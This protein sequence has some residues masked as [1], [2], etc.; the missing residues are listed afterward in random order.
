VS[1]SATHDDAATIGA[2]SLLAMCLV[3]FDHEALG[4]GG[5]C[6]AL[7]GRILELTSSIFRCDLR[8][9]WIS[10][11]G[12]LANLAVGTLALALT[13]L[14]ALGSRNTRL[15]LTLVACFSY[16]WESG[17]VIH[18]MHRRDGDLYF[19]GQDFLGEPSLAWRLAGAAAGFALFLYTMR[20]VWRAFDEL[21]P[22]SFAAARRAARIAWVSATLGAVGAALCYRGAGLADLRDAFLEIGASAFPLLWLWPMRRGETGA[23]PAAAP[24]ARDRRL[25]AAAALIYAGFAATLGRGIFG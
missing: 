3:T 23:G 17:Y 6:L 18:A 25:L 20:W 2:I 15:F 4:H 11:A 13:R 5:M 24:I 10:P 7:G 19:A 9:Q 12:P 16:F 8:S 14:T 22:A 1:D 21:W